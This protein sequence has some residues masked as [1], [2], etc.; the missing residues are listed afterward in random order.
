MYI[1]GKSQ[2]FECTK[3]IDWHYS[4]PTKGVRTVSPAGTKIVAISLSQY[5]V[6]VECPVCGRVNKFV[7]H[8]N[9]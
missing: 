1:E 8:R 5:E 9:E 6:K 7:H 4:E 2:C 3:I